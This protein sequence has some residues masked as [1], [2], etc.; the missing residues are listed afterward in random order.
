MCKHTR[1]GQP[2]TNINKHHLNSSHPLP[3]PFLSI[4]MVDH[5]MPY[6]APLKSIVLRIGWDS[7][8]IAPH[9]TVPIL[10]LAGAADQLVP[11]YHMQD[12]FKASGK[13][14]VCARMHV[15][16][17]GTHNETWLQG[18]KEYWESIQ[19]FM[20]EVFAAEKSGAYRSSTVN[21][22]EEWNTS[23]KSV[24]VGMGAENEKIQ[25]QSSIPTMPSNLV[26]MAKEATT[27]TVKRK[28]S[29]KKEI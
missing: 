3:P 18:G 15:V 1:N 19:T 23:R 27:A 2:H 14:S 5:L 20:A 12:L 7:G 25:V 21:G 6:I 26:G 24:A 11:P 9:I 28:D 13:A 16:E 22:P 17:D 29:V 4:Q 8:T 10:Y